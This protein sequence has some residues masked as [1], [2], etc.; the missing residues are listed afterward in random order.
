MRINELQHAAGG[1]KSSTG[2]GSDGF[3]PKL[4]LGITEEGCAM[5][6]GFP[7]KVEQCGFW[8][9]HAC[10]TMFFLIPKHVTSEKAD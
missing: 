1:H 9:E 4:P 7:M 6:T 10:T 3:H 2:V 8:P 5:I